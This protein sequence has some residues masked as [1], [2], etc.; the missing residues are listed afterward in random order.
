[1]PTESSLGEDAVIVASGDPIADDPG[2]IDPYVL[3]DQEDHVSSAVW[4]GLERGALR[5]HEHTSKL[6]EWRLTPKQIELVEKAG[7]KYF[8]KI[9]AFSRALGNATNKSQS[10]ISGCLTLLQCWSYW[11]INIGRPKLNQEHNSDVFPLALRWKQKLSG[12]RA[13]CDVV[14]YRKQL[15]CLQSSEVVWQPYENVESTIPEEFKDSLILGKS[16][17]TLI[18]LDKVERH[19][20]DRCLRQF[21]MHQPIPEEVLR[22]RGHEGEVEPSKIMRSSC[23]EWARRRDLTVEE[24][25]AIDENDYKRWYSKITRRYIGRH[26]PMESSFRLAVT[27]LTKMQELG[28]TL[29]RDNMTLANQRALDNIMN[30]LT[31]SLKNPFVSTKFTKGKLPTR[32]AKKQKLIEA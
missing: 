14:Q 25:D 12:L 10:T 8:R 4:E 6:E 16:K 29:S 2:P 26:T 18:C 15:D 22:I 21:G 5:C 31:E 24:D 3:Y 13:K 20:P 7:F 30:T 11:H 1:M 32:S 9:E 27:A 28:K 23:A 17:T 19:L